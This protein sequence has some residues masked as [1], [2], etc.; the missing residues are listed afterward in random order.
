LSDRRASI[1]SE[2][3]EMRAAFHA[4]V[5]RVGSEGR[6]RPSAVPG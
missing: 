1:Q 2:L 4:Q 3:E 5:E 6:N